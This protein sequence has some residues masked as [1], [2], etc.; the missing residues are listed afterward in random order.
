MEG[1]RKKRKERKPLKKEGGRKE[2]LRK[3][4]KEKH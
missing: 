3:V 4:W 1:R 2:V